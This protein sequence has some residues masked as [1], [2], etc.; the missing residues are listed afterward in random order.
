MS[1]AGSNIG[2][3]NGNRDYCSCDTVP[4]VSPVGV[5]PAVAVASLS[6]LEEPL[7]EDPLLDAFPPFSTIDSLPEGGVPASVGGVLAANKA[8]DNWMSTVSSRSYCT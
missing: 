5:E 6:L 1:D 4:G 2:S 8:I 3:R 7:L